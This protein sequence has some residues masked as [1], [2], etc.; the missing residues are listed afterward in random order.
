MGNSDDYQFGRTKP[1]RSASFGDPAYSDQFVRGGTLPLASAKKKTSPLD[2]T[3]ELVD[4]LATQ[5]ENKLRT[6]QILLDKF[7]QRMR[8]LQWADEVARSMA[9]EPPDAT[10]SQ[11]QAPGGRVAAKKRFAK[12]QLARSKPLPAKAAAFHLSGPEQTLGLT[13]AKLIGHDPALQR[14]VQVALFQ[15][16]EATR[17][18]EEAKTTVERARQSDPRSAFAELERLEVA[19]IQGKVFPL[20]NLHAVFKDRPEIARLFPAPPPAKG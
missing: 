12:P 11:L 8:I 10:P 14:R 2:V 15:F 9:A 4:E 6:C 13:V 7:A 1:L 5:S 17:A 16:A 20:C 18:V 3:A 19:K